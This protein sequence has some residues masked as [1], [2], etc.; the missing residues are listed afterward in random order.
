MYLYSLR[1]VQ[2]VQREYC[3]TLHGEE[4]RKSS[5]FEFLPIRHSS[6]REARYI[7][8]PKLKKLLKLIARIHQLTVA[9]DAGSL[10]S[11]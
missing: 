9:F 4:F 7:L 3:N 11:N 1:R 8:A 5:L 2:N 10:L 6:V